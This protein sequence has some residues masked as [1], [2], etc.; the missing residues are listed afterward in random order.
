MFIAKLIVSIGQRCF[1]QL[2]GHSWFFFLL[3]FTTPNRPNAE[4]PATNVINVPN[5]PSGR[6]K[7]DALATQVVNK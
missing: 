3:V 2:D 6:T 1:W 5:T 7:T 4:K